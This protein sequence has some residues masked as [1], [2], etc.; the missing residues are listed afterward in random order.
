M[1]SREDK[2]FLYLFIYRND[3]LIAEELLIL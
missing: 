2:L 3:L 1:I